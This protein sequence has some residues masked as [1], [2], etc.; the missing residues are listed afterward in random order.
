MMVLKPYR[1]VKTEEY[2]LTP[3]G[4][5]IA[6]LSK[7]PKVVYTESNF[8]G[9]RQQKVEIYRG[10]GG[11]VFRRQTLRTSSDL[12]ELD[13][14]EDLMGKINELPVYVKLLFKE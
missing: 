11:V 5:I 13:G 10:S 9:G 1:E 4:V 6:D 14:L 12:G 3:D 8:P 7:M 2:D